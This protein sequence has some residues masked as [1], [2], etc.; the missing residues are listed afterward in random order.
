MSKQMNPLK[1]QLQ[2]IHIYSML[3]KKIFIINRVKTKQT[4]KYIKHIVHVI[5]M[6]NRIQI[7]FTVIYFVVLQHEKIGVYI[8]TQITYNQMLQL[9]TKFVVE[10]G[11]LLEIS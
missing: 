6:F 4:S 11:I 3:F 2:I 1:Q 8:Y 7:V 10:W 5:T 9:N